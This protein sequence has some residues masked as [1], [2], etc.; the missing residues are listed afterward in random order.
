MGVENQHL[1]PKKLTQL[2]DKSKAKHKDLYMGMGIGAM[3]NMKTK[4]NFRIGKRGKEQSIKRSK[5]D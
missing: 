1:S 5:M 3:K 2:E 4:R